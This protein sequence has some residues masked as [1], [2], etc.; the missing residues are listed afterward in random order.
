MK[1]NGI[2]IKAFLTGALLCAVLVA[3]GSA[4]PPVSAEPASPAVADELD[5]AILEASTYLNGRVPKGS[6]AVFLNIR[7]DYPDLSEYILN[8]LSE[9]AVNA[10]T[11]S[12]VDRQ[13]LD[14]LRAELNFQ[15]SGEVSDESAQDIGKMLAAQTIVSGAVGKIGPLYRVQVKAIEVQSAGVQGQWS[16]NVPN[17]ATIAAL[18][19][20]YAPAPAASGAAVAAARSG[21]AAASPAQAQTAVPVVTPVQATVPAPTPAPAPEAPKTYKIGE[22]GPAGGFIFYDKGNDSDGW[23][24]LEAAPVSA[25]LKDLLWGPS[26]EVGGTKVEIGAGKRN[27]QIIVNHAVTAGGNYRAAWLCDLL[28]SG[29]YDDWFLP[30]KTELN[31]IYLNL[32]ERGLGGFT[33]AWYWSSSEYSANYSWAQNFSS[34]NQTDLG[35]DSSRNV[36]AIRQF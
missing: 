18:T 16:R 21:A 6:K 3:C 4:P 2:R 27:T 8:V 29:G 7:S 28:E 15:M 30:S 25:E 32:R 24:Y 35:K 33:N 36:R 34:G 26:G 10:G 13:Q 11:F 9:N 17:G 22:A 14:T 20:K 12:V 19:E 31:L 5:A 1:I 23:R